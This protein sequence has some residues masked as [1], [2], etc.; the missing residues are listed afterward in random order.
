MNRIGLA[1]FS[2][3]TGAH[4]Q[5]YSVRAIEPVE[6]TLASWA[7]DV[8]SDGR[9]AGTVAVEGGRRTFGF[10]WRDGVVEQLVVP[11]PGDFSVFPRTLDIVHHVAVLALTDGGYYAGIGNNTNFGF[12]S[13][14]YF[15]W[16]PSSDPYPPQ[17]LATADTGIGSAYVLDI[18]DTPF[19]VTGVGV[20]TVRVGNNDVRKGFIS[21]LSQIDDVGEPARMTVVNGFGGSSSPSAVFGVN[22]SGVSVGYGANAQGVHRAFRRLSGGTL[23]DL[24]A[25]GGPSSEAY[26]I[27]DEGH[28]VGRADVALGT[29]H[30]FLVLP[31]SAQMQDLGT[32]GGSTSAARAVNNLG[33]AVG[34]SWTA[35]GLVHAFLWRDG[36]M[37][38]LNSRIPAGSGWVLTQ[39]SAINDAGLVAGSGQIQGRTLAFVI[40][41]GACAADFDGD[42]FVTGIDFDLFVGA[43]EAGDIGADFDGDG[44]I[45][46]IDFDLF[47]HA[48]EAG[49]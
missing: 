15:A 25:L 16:I 20:G 35:D 44:F 40:H 24:G 34:E 19:F 14:P 23:S 49:C 29:P 17:Y 1:I 13:Q 22:F 7:T 2:L 6:G 21:L 33:H 30:A 26:D 38:D 48:F 27:S 39:A 37:I 32:L 5:I 9:V 10:V 4:A 47:V 36:Q 12:S 3:S 18:A 43:F 28:V 42:G 41:T 31:G 45:T 11:Q 46:G 8:T